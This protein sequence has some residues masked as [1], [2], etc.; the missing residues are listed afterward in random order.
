[1][2]HGI[3]TLIIPAAGQG[4]RLLPATKAIPKELLPNFDRP[5]LQFAIDEAIE[6]GVAGVVIVIHPA[7]RAIRE[8]LAPDAALVAQ[9]RASGKT[10]LAAARIEIEVPA[11]VDVV[12]VEQ[13]QA[14]GLGLAV[15][16]PDDLVFGRS[17]LPEMAESYVG[18]HMIE[19]MEVAP[20]EAWAYDTFRLQ[21]P[22]IGRMVAASGMVEKPQPGLTPSRLAAVGRYIL[23]PGIFATLRHVARAAG[24]QIQL[25]DAIARDAGRVPLS[26]F[27]FSDTRFDCGQRRRAAVRRPCAAGRGAGPQRVSRDAG[28]SCTRRA[29]LSDRKPKFRGTPP[30]LSAVP[31]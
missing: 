21:T 6:L 25:T 30:A 13:D 20:D 27:R 16:L 8:Y 17:C 15:L 18:G 2:S 29:D 22:A 7:K 11:E 4:H 31:E 12:F 9:L 19:A 26:D 3:A 10:S 23:D 1:M 5:A 28:P 14:L 24:S